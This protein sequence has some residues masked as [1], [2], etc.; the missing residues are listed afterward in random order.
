MNHKFEKLPEEILQPQK[1]TDQIIEMHDKDGVW[2][3]DYCVP[4]TPNQ[5]K[6]KL[7]EGI[8]GDIER[9][10]YESIKDIR[11]DVYQKFGYFYTHKELSEAIEEYRSDVNLHED[12]YKTF[13]KYIAYDVIEK[14]SIKKLEENWRF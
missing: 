11:C 13:M 4:G 3:T 8:I 1:I 6:R 7:L 12:Y 2:E 9:G 14:I 10:D 5:I